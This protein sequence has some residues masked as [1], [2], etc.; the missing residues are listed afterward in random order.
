MGE[1]EILKEFLPASIAT[2]LLRGCSAGFI[3]QSYSVAIN[4]A[5]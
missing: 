4:Y 1:K 3:F 2:P 5:M